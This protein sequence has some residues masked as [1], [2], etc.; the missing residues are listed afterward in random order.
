MEKSE[1][2]LPFRPPLDWQGLLNFYRHHLIHGLETVAAD[3]FERVFELGSAVG[4]FR[5][6]LDS[7]KK[8]LRLRVASDDAGVLPEVQRRV[9]KMFDLD[10]DPIELGERFA[11]HPHLGPLWKERP[12]LRI[13]RGWNPFEVAITTILGQLVSTTQGRALVRQ[14]IESHGKPIVHPRM[15]EQIRLFP[16]AAALATADLDLVRTSQARKQAIRT[17][18]Q[19]VVSRDIDLTGSDVAAIKRQLLALPGIGPWTSEYI[20]LRALGDTD[21]FPGSDLVLKR[22]LGQY[23]GIELQSLRPWRGYAAIH[24]WAAS[25][26][27]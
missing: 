13:A 23:P 9:R 16:S 27:K 10:A 14:L 25:A 24:L 15:G 20:G 19:L 22:S 17:L 6:D 4:V 2:L 11:A 18:S 3:T 7:A 1:V 26:K 21:A 5:V 8:C 12:G